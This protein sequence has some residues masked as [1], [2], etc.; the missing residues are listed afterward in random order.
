MTVRM[1]VV[2][3]LKKEAKSN[4]NASR[5]SADGSAGTTPKPKGHRTAAAMERNRRGAR[6]FRERQSEWLI[7]VFTSSLKFVE[8]NSLRQWQCLRCR[9]KVY[10]PDESRGDAG[11]RADRDEAL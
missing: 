7:P 2:Q 6:K 11:D 9:A 4:S 8:E 10:G 5:G 1:T 3:G